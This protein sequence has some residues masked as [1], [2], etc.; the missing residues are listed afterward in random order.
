M[1]QQNIK[2]TINSYFKNIRQRQ[3]PK[4]VSIFFLALLFTFGLDFGFINI[5]KKK[6]HCYLKTLSSIIPILVFLITFA[7]VFYGSN[8]WKQAFFGIG[9]LQYTIHVLLLY[10]SKYNVYQFI[11][12]LYEIHNQIYDKEY[13]FLSCVIAYNLITLVLKAIIC[14]SLCVSKA[15]DCSSVSNV[16]PTY[17]YCVPIKAVDLV[18]VAQ[19][20][21]YYYVYASLKLLRQRMENKCFD[22]IHV[23][24]QFIKIADCCDKIS[25][26]YGKLVSIAVPL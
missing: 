2:V 23:R 20:F 16:I 22:L 8:P 3:I 4:F 18:V 26:L 19:I 17:V 24:E 14:D 7:P 25:G 21:I 1:N 12:D 6:Y 13:L 11:M 9:S 5:F 10:V 15:I